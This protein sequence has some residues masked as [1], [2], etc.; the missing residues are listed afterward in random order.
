[1]YFSR[2]AL[3]STSK[4]NKTNLLFRWQRSCISSC[5]RHIRAAVSS[6]NNRYYSALKKKYLPLFFSAISAKLRRLQKKQHAF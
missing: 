2:P 1:M 5:S 4:K 6:Y 3:F